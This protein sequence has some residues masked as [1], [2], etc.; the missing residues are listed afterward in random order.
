MIEVKFSTSVK[1]YYRE[2]E[3]I[4][5]YV[6]K[7]AGARLGAVKSAWRLANQAAIVASASVAALAAKL[8][9]WRGCPT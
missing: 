7:N 5:S 6:A 2:D 4:Q 1:N 8:Q 9:F 3:A